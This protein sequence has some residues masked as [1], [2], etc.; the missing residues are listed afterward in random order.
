SKRLAEVRKK[1][2]NF[3]RPDGKTQVSVRYDGDNRPLGIDAVVVSTPH[4]E[5]GAYKT[6]KEAVMEEVV[7]PILPA[8]LVSNKTKFFINPTGRF[9]VGGPM[10]DVGL[11]GLMIIVA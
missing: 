3:L 6:Q 7:K 10:G 11:P 2:R 9:V 1:G 8:K 4:S 5:E